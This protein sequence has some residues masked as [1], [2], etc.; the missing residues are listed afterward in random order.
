MSQKWFSILLIC[1][2]KISEPILVLAIARYT[3]VYEFA[4]NVD[5]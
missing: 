3:Q 5:Y 2:S 4:G 1:Y